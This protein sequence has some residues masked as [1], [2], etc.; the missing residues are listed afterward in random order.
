MQVP[1]CE[2]HGPGHPG[3]PVGHLVEGE[4]WVSYLD[5]VKAL[6]AGMM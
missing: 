6:A 4:R 1:A 5:R 2:S 3:S